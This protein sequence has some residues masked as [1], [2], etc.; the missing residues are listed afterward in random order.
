MSP[1]TPFGVRNP[2]TGPAFALGLEMQENYFLGKRLVAIDSQGCQIFFGVKPFN[3]KERALYV[4][5]RPREALECLGCQEV[6]QD[7]LRPGWKAL[8]FF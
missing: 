8:G 3:R 5:T 6:D 4:K 7:F 1:T 2:H